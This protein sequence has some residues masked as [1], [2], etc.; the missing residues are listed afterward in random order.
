MAWH[1]MRSIE[2]IMLL[3]CILHSGIALYSAAWCIM[4]FHSTVQGPVALNLSWPIAWRQITCRP[5]DESGGGGMRKG[6][7]ETENVDLIIHAWLVVSVRS[8]FDQ[9]ES[10]RAR[11]AR[12]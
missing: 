5:A 12:D 10:K 2:Y 3:H 6:Q 1:A 11:S 9:L 8:A 4:A 7:E